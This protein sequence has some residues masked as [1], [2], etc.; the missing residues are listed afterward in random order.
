[1]AEQDQN[2]NYICCVLAS[3]LHVFPQ[4]LGGSGDYVKTGRS[5]GFGLVGPG[6][7]KGSRLGI[8]KFRRVDLGD[9]FN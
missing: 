6:A 9:K 4:Q 5:S 2:L 7:F 3:L 1:M 8:L